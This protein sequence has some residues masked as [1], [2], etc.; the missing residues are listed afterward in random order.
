MD[1]VPLGAIAAFLTLLSLYCMIV[2]AT[3]TGST[4]LTAAAIPRSRRNPPT[5]ALRQYH[6]PVVWATRSSYVSPSSSAMLPRAVRKHEKENVKAA[7]GMEKYFSSSPAEVPPRTVQ[8]VSSGFRN[9]LGPTT[10]NGA[11]NSQYGRQNGVK[12]SANGLA[13]A[14]DGSFEDHSGSQERP[15]ALNSKVSERRAAAQVEFAEDDFDSDI[16][17]DVEDPALRTAVAYPKLPQQHAQA[18]TPRGALYPTLPRQAQAQPGFVN[19]GPRAGSGYTP[20]SHLP[21]GSNPAEDS[22]QALLWSSSPSEHLAPSVLNR[23]VHDPPTVPQAIQRPAKRRT[24]PWHNEVADQGESASTFSK[25]STASFTPVPKDQKKSAYLWNTTASAIKEQ[26]KQHRA[27]VKKVV[28]GS[29]G[30]VD[31]IAKAKTARARPAK[32]FLSEEQQ[33]VLHLVLEKKNS[34]FFTGSAGTGKSVLMREIISALRKRYQRE[35]DRVACTASTGLAACNVG[36]VTLHS[37]AGIGL[38]KE[39]VPELVRKIKRNQK[40][41]QRWLRTKVLII[42][43]VSMVDGELFDKLE[44][45]ARQLRSNGRPFGG[46]QLVITG[47]F[48]QLPPVPDYGKVAKFAFDAA[49]WTT[50][51]EHTIGLHHIFRQK[52]PSECGRVSYAVTDADIMQ[53]LLACSMRCARVDCRS[54]PSRRS[55]AFLAI[56]S[57]RTPWKPRNCSLLAMKLTEPTTVVSQCYRAKSPFSRLG[58]GGPSLTRRNVINCCRTAWPRRRSH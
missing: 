13:K 43:E 52:D 31:D 34:V 53:S 22:S 9:P 48:F 28:K 14:F 54:H 40:A 8:S 37:F 45:V 39:D 56:P 55:G 58:M 16:D 32:V 26:Q 17:L 2:R 15:S 29:E 33:H 10:T 7:S 4:R 47:D 51:I 49:T 3:G 20:N 50:T 25:A 23:F 24:L 44:A 38:G 27:E 12:R 18:Q 36:G 42:D 57:S 46:I 30:S 5:L 41:K 6:R 21:T 35:P 1:S 11:K 19:V